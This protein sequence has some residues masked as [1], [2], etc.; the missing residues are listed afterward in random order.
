MKYNKTM[1]DPSVMED[2]TSGSNVLSENEY[3]NIVLAISEFACSVVTRT[4][5]PYGKTTNIDDSQHV[6][7]TKD[8]WTVLRN[9]RLSDPLYNTILNTIIGISFDLVTKVGDGTTSAL[10]GANVFLHAILEAIND[11]KSPLYGMRQS[12]LLAQINIVKDIIIDKLSNSEEIRRI[13]TDGDFSDIR[14]IAY[15]S[16]NG[17][18]L[19][20][21]LIQTIYKETHNPHIYVTLD[22]GDE[23]KAEIQDGYKYEGLILKH[24][25]Y[26]NSDD[27]TYV[28]SD[29]PI[30]VAVFNH[31]ITYNEHM[32]I[33]TTLSK[34]AN[35]NNTSILI[36]A[37][38]FDDII[39]TI[40]TNNIEQNVQANRVPNIIMMQVGMAT[41][42]MRTDMDDFL[43]LTNGRMF[44]Y[45]KVRAL[46]V[47]MH[48]SNPANANNK[49]EDELLT[50]KEYNYEKPEDLIKECL[51]TINHSVFGEKYVIISKYESIV[52]KEMYEKTVKEIENDFIDIA[53]RTNKS[54]NMLTKD[55]MEAYQRHVKIKGKMGVIKVGAV[56]E[57]EKHCYK[58]SIDDAVLAC[59]SAYSN[60]YIRG[61]N[62]T[63]LT[64]INKLIYE[65]Y[66]DE[67]TPDTV[68]MAILK[69]FKS[70]FHDTTLAV[71]ENKYPDRQD[72]HGES[73]PSTYNISIEGKEGTV[74]VDNLSLIETLM[75]NGKTFDLV[76]DTITKD[77]SVINSVSTDIEIINSV[78]GV[79]SILLTSDQFVSLNKQYDKKVS[80]RLMYE[81]ELEKAK[82]I[83]EGKILA[84]LEVLHKNFP[85]YSRE[86]IIDKFPNILQ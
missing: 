82:Y 61:L 59:K 25:C 52:N 40:L 35:Q 41:G 67:N 30:K 48:N 57:L 26:I 19:V 4:L 38:Y 55:Y 17:N 53:R 2:V 16:S 5:G 36:V 37:P 58:D 54:S 74:I 73:E 20:S 15:I 71:L 83:E 12:D 18:D 24:K 39:T 75:M 1:A 22:S 3:R 44:D 9:L 85:Q 62:L 51:G 68:D 29:R 34:Y 33:I 10:T 6:A 80:R 86:E 77:W 21:D 63:T 69:L 27:G 32:S 42:A 78:V 65:Q 72:R 70:V 7:P 56:T 60:G 64:T 45:G 43:M 47:T 31:N 66:V 46:H 76:T 50:T 81:R 79:L 84:R 13:N 8:G 11:P 28:I 14:Q 49:I 23:I